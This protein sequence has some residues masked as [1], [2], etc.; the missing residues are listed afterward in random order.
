M[1]IA[2]PRP[3]LRLGQLLLGSAALLAFLVTVV[4]SLGARDSIQQMGVAQNDHSIWN[5]TQLEIEFLKLK[6][7][8]NE[9][10]FSDSPDAD[11]VRRR[12]DIFYSRIPL[13]QSNTLNPVELEKVSDLK[14]FLDSLIP[15]IDGRRS[16]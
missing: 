9:E 4:L 5:A 10:F 3:V 11:R 6:S 2:Q 16:A 7:A 14:S 12:F 1:T 15:L 8:I 13:I